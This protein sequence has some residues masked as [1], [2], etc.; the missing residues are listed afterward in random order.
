MEHYLPP[1]GAYSFFVVLKSL[2]ER[3]CI[4]EGG[5]LLTENKV[6][7]QMFSCIPSA[8]LPFKNQ[9]Y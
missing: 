1:G 3:G 5:L 9:C 6:F 7:M 4:R 8:L 2:I